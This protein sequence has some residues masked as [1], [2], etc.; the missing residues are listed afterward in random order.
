MVM[1]AEALGNE[2]GKSKGGQPGDQ[3]NKEIVVREFK[4]KRDYAWNCV[5]RCT[6]RAM[7]EKAAQYA[8]EIAECPQ[9]GYDQTNRWSGPKNIEKVG[10]E[11]I[12]K[13]K[14]GDF[15]CSSLVIE[16]YRLAG[17]PVKM[18]GYTGSMVKIFL[19]TGYFEKLDGEEYLTSSDYDLTGDVYVAEERHTL[20]VLNDGPKA[21]P[22]PMTDYVEIIKGRM[23]C[24]F[25]PDGKKYRTVGVEDN[26]IPY[27]GFSEPDASGKLWWAVRVDDVDGYISSGLPKYARL[28]EV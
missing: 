4:V 3:N 10:I 22:E 20:I 17:L 11:N 24:R 9:F 28:V 12:D 16:C 6:D 27:R 7:A 14:A 23:W 18:T 2:V 15:D 1:I 8:R 26:P 19:K 5:L 25:T 13:A 21:D